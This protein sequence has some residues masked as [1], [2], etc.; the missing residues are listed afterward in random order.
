MVAPTG[1]DPVFGHGHVLA[2]FCGTIGLVYREKI[3]A[4]KIRSLLTERGDEAPGWRS[5]Y[6]SR[7]LRRSGPWQAGF[8]LGASVPLRGTSNEPAVTCARPVTYLGIGDDLGGVV[9]TA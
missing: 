5:C 1:F 2:I 6:G 9:V 3:D 8:R 7:A 4:T